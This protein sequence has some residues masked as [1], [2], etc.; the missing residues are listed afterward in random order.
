LGEECLLDSAYRRAHSSQRLAGGPCQVVAVFNTSEVQILK[1]RDKFKTYE[2]PG[3]CTYSGHDKV[4]V[5][6]KECGCTLYTVP[7]KWGGEKMVIRTSLFDGGFERW[8]PTQEW[9]VKRR[10]EWLKP[11]DGAKQFEEVGGGVGM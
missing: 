1:T 6:C 4:K 10:P 3:S 11:I 9:F 2:I 7:M 5:A 8:R